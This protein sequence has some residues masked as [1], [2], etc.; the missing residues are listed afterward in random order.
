MANTGKNTNRAQFFITLAPLP[1]LDG[2]HVVFG[3]VDSKSM[4]VVRKIEALGSKRGSTTQTIT[5]EKSGL[6]SNLEVECIE[7]TK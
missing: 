3:H 5:I 6:F 2:K 1:H 4:H 7:Y